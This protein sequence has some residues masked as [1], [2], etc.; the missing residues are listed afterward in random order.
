MAQ[1][2][3]LFDDI[4]S[5]VDISMDGS[6]TDEELVSYLGGNSPKGHLHSIGQKNNTDDC[7]LDHVVSSR[8][9]QMCM[10][11]NAVIAREN[12][13][14]KKEYIQNLE[15]DVESLRAQNSELILESQAMQSRL[16]S[17]VSEVEYLKG[18]IANQ[19]TLSRLIGSMC[20][21]PGV[22]FYSSFAMDSEQFKEN[23]R[24][25]TKNK[26][27]RKN[28]MIGCEDQTNDNS[29]PKTKRLSS[30]LSEKKSSKSLQ[31]SNFQQQKERSNTKG[32]VCLHV[33]G[34]EVSLEFC[35]KCSKNALHTKKAAHL[36]GDHSYGKT[37]LP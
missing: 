37:H 2:N 8:S 16:E 11:R 3:E 15:K 4:F 27:K 5:G 18:V 20:H 12:R 35:S 6:R 19:S 30:R 31:S 28:A 26:N 10:S 1:E 32:G 25:E 34:E 29:E 13:Q 33:S 23:E 17:L 21:T 7:R 24:L 22:R 9:G 14:K 36:S